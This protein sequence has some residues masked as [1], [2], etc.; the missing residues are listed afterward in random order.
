MFSPVL[1]RRKSVDLFEATQIILIKMVH[2][3]EENISLV[4]NLVYPV[5][6]NVSQAQLREHVSQADGRLLLRMYTVQVKLEFVTSN[7]IVTVPLKND[8]MSTVVCVN[9]KVNSH[10]SSGAYLPRTPYHSENNPEMNT[11]LRCRNV[12]SIANV[13]CHFL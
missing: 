4:Y 12:Q 2:Y 11:T 9:C 5:T 10:K 3:R 8:I 1:F 7:K 6:K 13:C